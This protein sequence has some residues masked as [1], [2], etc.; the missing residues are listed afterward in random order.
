MEGNERAFREALSREATSWNVPCEPG[1][2]DAIARYAALLLTWSS[3]INLTGAVSLEDLAAE[4]L[5]DSFALA[6]RLGDAGALAAIDVGSGGGLPA[7]PLAILCPNLSIKLLEPIAK[8]AAFLR[9]AIRELALAPR[10]TVETRRVQALTPGHFDVAFS[11]ATFP[12][13]SWL[14]IAAD[15]VQPGGRI[16]LLA[17]SA[18]EWS[19][20]PLQLTTTGQWPYLEDRRW[21]V[22]LVK[23]HA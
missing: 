6:S 22:E 15:L 16:F 13:R 4:H 11:R 19:A 9:T 5:P 18:G 23:A 20:P 21:L 8:K 12:P 10:V 17:T 1:Q 14:P 7:L 2:R 3:R